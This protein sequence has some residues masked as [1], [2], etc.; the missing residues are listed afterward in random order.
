LTDA[1]FTI[2]PPPCS[3]IAATAAR[4]AR[5]AEKKLSSSEA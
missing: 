4:V 2:V 3:S 1:T 5:S